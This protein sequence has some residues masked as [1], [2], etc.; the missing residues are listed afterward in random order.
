MIWFT[1]MTTRL[2]GMAKPMPWA[3][4]P[5]VGSI[6]AS[7]GMPARRPSRSTSAPPEFPGLIG[8]E[9]WIMF[10]ITVAGPFSIT[11]RCSVLTMPTVTDSA[12]PSGAPIAS[13]NWP[14]R[15]SF[16]SV[17]WIGRSPGDVILSTA[18]SS[19]ASIPA[20][21][22]G[23]V[24]PVDRV[25]VYGRSVRGAPEEDMIIGDDVAARVH[26]DAR[27]HALHAFDLDDRRAGGGR[28]GRGI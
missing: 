2:L 25:T 15:R 14:T 23:R 16:E 11:L 28:G 9:V 20:M 17:T 8:A 1:I 24:A 7:V 18:R 5:N 19:G 27:A 22:A 26:D 3:A 12:K 10:G 13:V 21:V 4:V 6:A